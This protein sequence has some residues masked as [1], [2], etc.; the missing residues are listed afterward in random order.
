MR[1]AYLLAYSGT[2]GSREDVKSILEGLREVV[3][4]RYDLPNTFYLISDNSAEELADAIHR[5][6][7]DGR[8]IVV[9][10]GPNHQGWL[11]PDSWYLINH[12][13]HKPKG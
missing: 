9:E 3:N 8:F 12:K 2:L 11:T 4:W 7:K 6:A 13:R 10:I 1:R 5:A